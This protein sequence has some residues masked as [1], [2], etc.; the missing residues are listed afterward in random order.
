MAKNFIDNLSEET[1]KGMYKKL[2][3]GG[4]PFMAPVGYKNDPVSHEVLI[5][6]EYAHYIKKAFEEF[7]TGRYSLNALNEYLYQE[8]FRSKRAKKKPNKEAMKRVLTNKFFYG[9]MEVKGKEYIG[10]HKPLISKDLFDKV[11][12]LIGNIRKPRHNVKNL[13][14]SALMTC[15]HCGRSIT[16]E[17]KRKANGT[18]YVYYHCTGTRGECSNVIYVEQT[19]IERSFSLAVSQ[20]QIP[21]EIVELTKKALLESH[22]DQQAYS[23]TALDRL[24]REYKK[25]GALLDASYEDKLLGKI[26]LDFWERKSGEWR[27]LQRGILESIDKQK[28]AQANYQLEGINFLELAKNAHSLYERQPIEQKQL[29]IRKLFSNCKIKDGTVCFDWNKPFDLFQKYSEMKKW[30]G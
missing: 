18:T 2:E 9:V 30:G 8:G 20:L 15:G 1:K 6:N 23:N 16:G 7:S 3:K 5:D 28:K 13:A 24:N 10:S 26:D 11:Q 4:Y 22:S 14:F 29:L 21:E 27:R 25:L 19:K 17:E 12:N